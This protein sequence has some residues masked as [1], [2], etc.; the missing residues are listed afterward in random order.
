MKSRL[1][2]LLE[3]I[4]VSTDSQEILVGLTDETAKHLI[5]LN[6]G[7]EAP[8]CAENTACSNNGTCCGNST[9]SNNSVCSRNSTC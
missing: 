8:Q 7:R 1:E 6:G 3:K 5:F 2:R 9:C 4:E